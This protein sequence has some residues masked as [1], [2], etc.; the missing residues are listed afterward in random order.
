MTRQRDKYELGTLATDNLLTVYI[1]Q[2]KH[3]C[4]ATVRD[5]GE[6]V[7]NPYTYIM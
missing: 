2:L 6:L 1:N 5:V 7:V 3:V 4:C